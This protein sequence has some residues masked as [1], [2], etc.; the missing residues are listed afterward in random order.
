VKAAVSVADAL[1]RGRESFRGQAW[2]DA[3]TRLS[4]ADREAPL[5]PEDLERLATAAYMVGRDTDSADL[6]ARAPSRASE[7]G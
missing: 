2:G 7:P 6:W 1:E 5:A 4:A 3:Y